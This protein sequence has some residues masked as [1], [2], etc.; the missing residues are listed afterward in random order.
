MFI[1]SL[2]KSA[3][4]NLDGGNIMQGLVEHLTCVFVKLSS[5]YVKLYEAI[6]IEAYES[7]TDQNTA[8]VAL[9]S[10]I[11]TNL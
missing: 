8:E 2:R 4:V 6:L 9:R 3:D 5:I 7:K 11:N 10:K 1:Y